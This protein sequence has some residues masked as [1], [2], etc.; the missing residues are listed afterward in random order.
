MINFIKEN[1]YTVV[2]HFLNQIAIAVFGIMLA[3]A[4]NQ[5]RDLL[6]L[7]S[8]ASVLFYVT[9]LYTSMWDIGAKDK[10]K[11]DGL[12]LSLRPL[13]GLQISLLSNIPNFIFVIGMFICSF[14]IMSGGGT[15][16][17]LYMLD[18]IM[19]LF[20]GMFLGIARAVPY[21]KPEGAT[22]FADGIY[23]PLFWLAATIPSHLFSWL[24][25]YFGSKGIR[26]LSPKTYIS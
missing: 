9:L 1:S 8:I 25:Y 14:I 16:G 10:I 11:I 13:F 6:V 12:R 17:I 22:I 23:N 3:S 24:G 20:M 15:A 18:S 2:K 19:R 7:T 21:L 5:N 26:I 4:T